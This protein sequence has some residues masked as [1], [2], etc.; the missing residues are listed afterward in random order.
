MAPQIQDKLSEG[1]DN[2]ARL[3]DLAMARKH[4]LEEAYQLHRFLTDAKEHV[5]NI[6]VIHV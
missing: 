5:S 6:S 2:W 4:K 1:L 3:E